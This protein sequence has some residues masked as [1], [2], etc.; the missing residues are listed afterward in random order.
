[1]N[2]EFFGAAQQVTGSLTLLRA[3]GKTIMIDCGLQ[4]GGDDLPSNQHLP[5]KATEV[6]VVL[7][8]HAHKIGRASCRERV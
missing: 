1:M 8:T 4:Q 2:I 6:D 7:L 5:L 3:C